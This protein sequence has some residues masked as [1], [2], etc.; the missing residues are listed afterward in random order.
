[1]R[2][3]FMSRNEFKIKE[4]KSI[5]EASGVEIVAVDSAIDE[6][7][8]DD[9]EKLVKDKCI[10]AFQK[11]GRPLFVEHTG[12][13]INALNGFPA[14]LTQ[15][16]WDTLQADR[17]ATIFGQMADTAVTAKTRIGYCD[18]KNVMQFEGAIS[19]KIS[20]E[21]R[22]DRAFQWDCIFIPDGYAQTFAE[23]GDKKNEMSMRKLALEGFRAYLEGNSNA[24]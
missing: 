19:G 21:P 2:L 20:P 22:G 18:G 8:T 10:K 14:G 7:Q 11:V 5:L 12:L 15:V 23:L 9:V 6:I 17:V 16:F 13:Y 1:M 24:R 4:V 3:R